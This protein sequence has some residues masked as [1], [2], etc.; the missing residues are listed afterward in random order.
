MIIE[1]QFKLI[2]SRNTFGCFNWPSSTVH[3]HALSF[4]PHF[5]VGAILMLWVTLGQDLCRKKANLLGYSDTTY[6]PLL[7]LYEPDFKSTTLV[8]LFS[9]LF[10]KSAWFCRL[11]ARQKCTYCK[12]RLCL[13]FSS[14]ASRL[15]ILAEAQI[16]LRKTFWTINSK[17]YR[18]FATKFEISFYTWV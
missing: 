15:R 3:V 8:K 7:D 17:A 16:Q 12:W 5:T 13:Q 9:D 14:D 4:V 10:N 6:D 11:Q 2:N 18:L 1:I